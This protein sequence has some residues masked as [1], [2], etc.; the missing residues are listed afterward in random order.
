MEVFTISGSPEVQLL[1]P[2][3][4]C[5]NVGALKVASG[6]TRVGGLGLGGFGIYKAVAHKA[7]GPAVFSLLGAA[8]LWLSGSRLAK[9]AGLAEEACGGGK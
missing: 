9:A 8:A 4:P 2:A 3:P 7:W 6:V 1:G 5:P